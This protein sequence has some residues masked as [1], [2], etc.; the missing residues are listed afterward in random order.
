[1]QSK[2]FE[3]GYSAALSDLGSRFAKLADT[4]QENISKA[5]SAA[6]IAREDHDVEAAQKAEANRDD[7]M[8]SKVAHMKA[9]GVVMDVESRRDALPGARAV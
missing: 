2:D 3:R 1:M 9:L 7:A 8:K 5:I 4:E 6:R